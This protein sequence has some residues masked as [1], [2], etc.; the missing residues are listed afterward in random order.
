VISA[1]EYKVITT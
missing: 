1:N